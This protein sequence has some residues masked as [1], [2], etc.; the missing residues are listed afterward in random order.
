MLHILSVLPVLY[1]VLSSPVAVEDGD[2]PLNNA[3]YLDCV[4]I[5]LN[6]GSSICQPRTHDE[7]K[8]KNWQ[9]DSKMGNMRTTIH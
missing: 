5:L 2:V 4:K 3:R 8:I 1:V 9:G 6:K 7:L